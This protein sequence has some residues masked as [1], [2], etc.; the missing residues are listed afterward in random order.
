MTMDG[1]TAR[2]YRTGMGHKLIITAA[3]AAIYAVLVTAIALN[4]THPAAAAWTTIGVTAV[5]IGGALAYFAPSLVA[6]HRQVRNLTQVFVV[7]LL[8]GWT[9]VGW[10][11]ALVMAFAPVRP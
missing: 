8:T 7:N 2:G 9:F 10:V 1:V 3:A 6:R 5:L 11:I 4:N